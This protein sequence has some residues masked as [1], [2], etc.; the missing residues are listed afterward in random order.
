M[1]LVS[2][3]T[4]M[5]RLENL[6][7]TSPFRP[8]NLEFQYAG[9]ELIWQNADD[10]EDGDSARAA[11]FRAEFEQH[12]EEDIPRR[13]PKI[14][15]GD[16]PVDLVI[17]VLE[18]SNPNA[19]ERA[20][21]QNPRINFDLEVRDASSGEVIFVYD[22]KETDYRPVSRSPP[23]G[24]SIDFRIGSNASRLANGTVARIIDIIRRH[25]K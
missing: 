4:A 3:G 7:D 21:F 2:C 12:I 10:A 18:F 8:S 23:D 5:T 19:F 16:R 14:L 17:T 20:L 15:Q 24:V 11:E 1:R 6:A 13:L 25:G 9:Y 22:E